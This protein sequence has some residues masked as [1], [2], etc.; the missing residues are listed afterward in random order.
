MADL[1]NGKRSKGLILGILAFLMIFAMTST[2]AIA[3]EPIKIGVAFGRPA[4]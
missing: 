1:K 3:K 2:A 4:T